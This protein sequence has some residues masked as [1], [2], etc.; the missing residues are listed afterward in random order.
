MFR[1][2][3]L[4]AIL[5]LPVGLAALFLGEVYFALV[6]VLIFGI[7]SWEFCQ[8]FKIGGYQPADFLLVSGVVAFGSL[9]A[10]FGTQWDMVLLTGLL[11]VGMGY[12]L[13]AYEKGR[14]MAVIDF[15][16]TIAGVTYIG[17]LGSY[18]LLIRGLPMGE[19]WL[20]VTLT[21]VWLADMGAYFIGSWLGRTPLAP[22][23]SPKKTWEGY[24]AGILISIVGT[25]LFI[26]LY[27][28][29][30]MPADAGITLGRGV[31]IAV[32]LSVFPTMGDLGIS[33]FK[34]FF[35]VKDS[36]KLLPGHG[37][38]LDRSD[39]WLWAAGI[40]YY[41]ITLVFLR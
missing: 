1:Q 35:E 25:P 2:R 15:T 7:A 31:L 39:S 30:G 32:G 10:Q 3:F 40:G 21:G 17:V 36:G 23:L 22:R 11:L 8:L 5:L 9:R 18:F 19:W 24:L 12:H 14:D 38:L 6:I 4:V 20:M 27:R 37:G 33:M 26:M 34:R 28:K 13:I 16:I 29:L 41:L